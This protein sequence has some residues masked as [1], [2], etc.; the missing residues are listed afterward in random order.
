MTTKVLLV[1]YGPDPV[2]VVAFIKDNP[3]R[4]ELRDAHFG[5]PEVVAPGGFK[6][7]YVHSNQGLVVDESEPPLP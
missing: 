7:F 5:K 3:G 1:N 2:R 6:E 4:R